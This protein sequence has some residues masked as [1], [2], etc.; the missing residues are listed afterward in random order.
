MTTSHQ[1][2]WQATWQMPACP[3]LDANQHVDVCIVG[4]G[5]AG[6]TTAYLLTQAGKSVAVLDDGPLA[7]GIT[8]VTTAHLTNMMDDRY[9]ELERLHGRENSR[10]A[11]ESHSA[12]IDRIEM[13]AA[14]ERISCEFER[15]DGYLFLAEGDRI[16]TLEKEI[17]A[18]QRAGLQGVELVQRAPFESFDTGACLRFPRQAQ[19][20]PLKYLA[21]LT[22]AILAG[23]G[24]IY[25]DTHAEHIEGGTPALVYA[26]T[27]II[28]ADAVVVATNVPV[29]DRVAI[30]TKQAP[31]MTYVIGARLRHG[32]VPRVLAW[33]TGDPY[34]YIRT[35]QDM[36]I[37]GGEDHK[38]GQASD[39]VERHA[40]LE[41]WTRERFPIGAV[42]LAWGGQVMEP[43]DYLS[44]TGRNP[45]DKDNVFVHTGDSGMGLTHATIAGMLLT[46]LICGRPNP[47][48]ALYDPSRKRV[49][50]AREYTA[51]NLN[52][53]RQYTDWLKPGEVK[54]VDEIPAGSGAIL[55][56]GVHKI[57][58]YR[59]PS[60]QVHERSAACPHLGCMVHWN[61]AE[62]TWDCACHGSR[63]DCHGHVINGP[64]NRDLSP[65]ESTPKQRAA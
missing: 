50:A 20:H 34:H 16:E 9:F 40:R 32:S 12:A 8:Q 33:D 51:E 2:I 41:A 4:A 30:H 17:A 38:S 62:R 25:T 56:R 26:N 57:A 6:L 48:A 59:D 55:G 45:M 61:G 22:R 52:V 43:I 18:T 19:F 27:Y 1:S 23:G 49:A 35:Y 44:F 29:N 7:G 5:M 14:A 64:A 42:E 46:D 3:R 24:R 39:T 58:V 28:T 15:V 60:G 21:G 11:A 31:Y 37:V 54:S 53:A 10:L 65:V 63:F 13:I 47:W 36:L